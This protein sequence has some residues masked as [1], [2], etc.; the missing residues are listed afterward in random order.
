MATLTDRIFAVSDAYVFK[1]IPQDSV[2]QM[3]FHELTYQLKDFE[4]RWLE[5]DATTW[6]VFM[7]SKKELKYRVFLEQLS[8]RIAELLRFIKHWNGPKIIEFISS[9]IYDLVQEKIILETMFTEK[10]V[11]QVAM[12]LTILNAYFQPEIF[13]LKLVSIEEVSKQLHEAAKP[14]IERFQ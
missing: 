6:S 1:N 3:L 2:Q 8:F 5:H 14:L 13:E 11:N 4:K 7:P 12:V 9:E 10:E